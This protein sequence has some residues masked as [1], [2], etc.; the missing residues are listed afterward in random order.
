MFAGV[1]ALVG[2]RDFGFEPGRKHIG[3]V[4]FASLFSG[5]TKADGVAERFDG[6]AKPGARPALAASDGL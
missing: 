4:Q 2:D 3:S 1:E 5:E 6:G